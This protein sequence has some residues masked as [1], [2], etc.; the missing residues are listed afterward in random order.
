MPE[1]KNEKFFITLRPQHGLYRCEAKAVRDWVSS[2]G[3]A[4]YCATEDAHLG[5]QATHIHTLLDFG[6]P[7][8]KS[9]L[10]RTIWRKCFPDRVKESLWKGFDIQFCPDT[11]WFYKLG[12]L[13]KEGCVLNEYSKIT[14][15][16]LRI[17]YA[18][19]L[20]ESKKALKGKK[21]GCLPMKA[22]NYMSF[23][24]DQRIRTLEPDPVKN[25]KN[26]L[27]TDRY[28]I[29]FASKKQQLLV[30]R[31]LAK[32]EEIPIHLVRHILGDCTQKCDNCGLHTN[33]DV[34][35]CYDNAGLPCVHEECSHLLR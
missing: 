17:G 13:Q 29:P 3:C 14:D 15:A 19:Y 31:L 28:T 18:K 27:E 7:R 32:G 8:R 22:S 5:P 2:L 25:M 20:E 9:N 6:V 12:Y 16:D 1:R 26:L 11:S 23:I 24:R 21:F 10:R 35:L 4:Y 30:E 33:M 34:C